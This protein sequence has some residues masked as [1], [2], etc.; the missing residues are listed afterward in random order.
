MPNNIAIALHCHCEHI[1]SVSPFSYA[2]QGFSWCCILQIFIHVISMNATIR[3]NVTS[4][5]M[6]RANTN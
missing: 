6:E 1:V 5:I 2:S 3:I 4:S